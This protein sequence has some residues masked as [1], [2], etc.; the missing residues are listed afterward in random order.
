MYEAFPLYWPAGYKRTASYQR[1]N[2]RFE[3][4]MDKSQQFL[5]KELDRLGATSLVISTNIPVRKDGGLYTDYMRRI[6]DDPGVAIYFYLKGKQVTMCCDQ[7]T[8]VWENIYA[9]GKGIEAL[10]GMER[11]GVSEFM[12][13]AFTGFQELPASNSKTCW[14]ILGS[15]NP[16]KDTEYIKKAYLNLAKIKHPDAGGTVE[17]FQELQQAYEH[18]LNYAKS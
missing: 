1:I 9:L 8:R 10:R 18:A 15:I 7:Y 16:T 12:E 3:Q 14:E 6:I 2:S 17:S 11:W 5:R 4:T 13:R